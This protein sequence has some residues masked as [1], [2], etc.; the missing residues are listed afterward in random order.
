MSPQLRQNIQKFLV[1]CDNP[2][3]EI[4]REAYL[5]NSLQTA[6][7]FLRMAII[8]YYKI[9]SDENDLQSA[10]K[11]WIEAVQKYYENEPNRKK[12]TQIFMRGY[13]SGWSEREVATLA[14]KLFKNN[15]DYPLR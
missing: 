10:T 8:D 2:T 14:D 12:L 9:E 15:Q 3:N 13:F 11:T 7:N 1:D 5:Y 4:S 6:L